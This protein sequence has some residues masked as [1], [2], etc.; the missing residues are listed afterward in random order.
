MRRGGV[1]YMVIGGGGA[2]LYS[3]SGDSSTDVKKRA[4]RHHFAVFDVDGSQVDLKVIGY[5]NALHKFIPLP[6]AVVSLSCKSGQSQKWSIAKVAVPARYPHRY[7][8]E[9]KLG[10]GE[11]FE[12]SLEG[13]A[14]PRLKSPAQTTKAR[15][16][17]HPAPADR[18]CNR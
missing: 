17:P 8:C 5:D 13:T 10:S 18:R 7:L 4:S 11:M 3:F 6:L 9:R 2:S 1:N 16:R 14:L 12:H 15:F